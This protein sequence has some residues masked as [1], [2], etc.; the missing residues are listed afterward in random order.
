MEGVNSVEFREVL[1]Q[2]ISGERLSVESAEL[3]LRGIM[4]GEVSESLVASFLTALAVRKVSSEELLGFARAMRGLAVTV[5]VSARPLL[6][7]CGTGGDKKGTF[8]IST[9]VA[10]VCAGAGIR[11]AKHGNRSATSLCGSADVLERLGVK[12]DLPPELVAECVEKVGIG[13]IFARR[14]HPAMKNVAK[15][16]SELPFP[17]IFNVLG[18]LSNPANPELQVIGVFSGELLDT[19]ADALIG[20]GVERGFVVFGKE[21]L[22]EVS[23]SGETEVIEIQ[24]GSKRR[25]AVKPE[26]F[27]IKASSLEAIRGG[28]VDFNA[29]I[30]RRLVLGEKS[31][32][33]DAVVINSAVALVAGGKAKN[34]LDGKR[35]A[36][37]VLDS[38]LAKEKLDKWVEFCKKY[39]D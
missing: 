36:E 11:V 24:K 25:Y 31:S 27:G 14:Y 34:F 37:E 38:G 10:L 28:D 33:R 26:D 23:I 2:S 30:I 9:A 32:Y 8:N 29:E 39:N 12:I 3:A 6:D 13:F 21:G 5:S 19:V 22:D 4:S 16:R 1:R 18:P 35:F 7:T 15:L 20:L 17:T